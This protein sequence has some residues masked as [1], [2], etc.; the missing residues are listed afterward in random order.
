MQIGSE[1]DPGLTSLLRGNE[2]G[3]LIIPPSLRPLMYQKAAVKRVI[4]GWNAIHPTGI[5]Q[6]YNS[7][8][9]LYAKKFEYAFSVISKRRAA[10]CAQ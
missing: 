6:R 8:D 1:G 7:G 10:A 2:G 5:A 9:S 4:T 3:D